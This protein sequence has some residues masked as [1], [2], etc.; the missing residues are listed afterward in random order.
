MDDLAGAQA[1]EDMEESL[2]FTADD[3]VRPFQGSFTRIAFL[4]APKHDDISGLCSR[5]TARLNEDGDA[6]GFAT[7]L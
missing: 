7:E 6:G 1:Q 2:D 4:A 3:L 5:A